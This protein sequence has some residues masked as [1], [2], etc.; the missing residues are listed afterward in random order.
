MDPLV[1]D[2]ATV[3][4]KRRKIFAALVD[5]PRSKTELDSML[6]CSRSTIDRAIR[7]LRD[8][9]LVCYEDGVWLPTL[10]GRCAYRAH[11][12][13]L[14]Y[15]TDLVGVAPLLDGLPDGSNISEKMLSGAAVSETDA[16]TPDM[17]MEEFLDYVTDASRVRFMTPAIVMGFA[18]TFY[19]RVVASEAYELELITPRDVYE[20]VSAT[21]PDLAESLLTD[22]CVQLYYGDTSFPFGTWIVDDSHAGLLVF[23]EHG[24]RGLLV[25]DSLDAVE[26][27][28][29]Q[30]ERVKR[31]ASPISRSRVQH[32]I[33]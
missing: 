27:A 22:E 1:Q 17:V 4:T 32:R 16:S 21:Y 28:E 11:D 6:D 5:Q 13:Y 18:K 33:Q 26:W 23:T 9:N 30:Y 24:I 10:L 19:E 12:T 15:L 31:S 2:V 25:N 20:R 29:T 7:A 3:L 8:A 14:D